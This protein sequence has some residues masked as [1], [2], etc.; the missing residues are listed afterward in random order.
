MMRGEP[1]VGSL[2]S[3]CRHRWNRALRTL[4]RDDHRNL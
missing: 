2:F 1:C 3:Q 4:Y